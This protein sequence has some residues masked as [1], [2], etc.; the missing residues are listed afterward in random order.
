MQKGQSFISKFVRLVVSLS[1]GLALIVSSNTLLFAQTDQST[2]QR[3]TPEAVQTLVAPIALY[4]DALVAQILAASTTP[5]EI[6]Q[7]DR[8]L[9]K[10]SDLQSNQLAT[11]V[12]QQPWDPSVKALTAFPKVLANMDQNLSWTSELGETYFEQQQ[13]VMDAIQVLRQRAEEAGNLQSSAQ[14]RIIN[15]GPSIVIEPGYPDVCYLPVYDPWLVY[16]A[17]LVPYPGYFF[18]PVVAVPFISFGPAIRIGFL[19]GFGWGWPAWG[20]NW[21]SRVVVFNR[22]P[23]VPRSS[24]FFHRPVLATGPRLPGPEVVAPRIGGGFG[25]SR[26]TFDRNHWIGVNRSNHAG[27]FRGFEGRGFNR[28][29]FAH[30]AGGR[31]FSRSGGGRRR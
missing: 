24:L 16:G 21:G 15:E 30:G 13:D 14:E 20:F 4:P 27:T 25:R 23:Y 7:A 1:S 11:A 3:K 22:F 12:D 6:V 9:Q 18:G 5:T 10:H 31:S 17:P 8:W 28:S 29:N 2:N 19:S 26:Q